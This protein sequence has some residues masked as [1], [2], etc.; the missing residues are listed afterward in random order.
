VIAKGR[1]FDRGQLDSLVAD[2]E[3]R[4]RG[5]KATPAP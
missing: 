2:V 4:G 1:Y 3:R 5:K